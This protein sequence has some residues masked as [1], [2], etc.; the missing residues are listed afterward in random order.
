MVLERSM[1]TLGIRVKAQQ[2]NAKRLAKYLQKH[3]AV[4][5]RIYPGLKVNA[6][7]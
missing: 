5:D 2:R 6:I 7:S 3:A 4:K 1:K